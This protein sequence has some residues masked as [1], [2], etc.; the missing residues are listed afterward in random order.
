MNFFNNY[1]YIKGC[2]KFE[3]LYNYIFFIGKIFVKLMKKLVKWLY[4]NVNVE[5]I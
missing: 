3:I 2:N 1:L 4:S 5:E